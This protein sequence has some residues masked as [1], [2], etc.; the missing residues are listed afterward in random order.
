MINPMIEVAHETILSS[1]EPLHQ[2]ILIHAEALRARRDLEHAATEWDKSGRPGSALRT[3]KLLLRY[4]DAAAPRSTTA[5]AYLTACK[6]RRTGFRVA[7]SALGLLFILT[8]GILFHVNKS[9]YPP[10]LAAKALFVQLGIWPVPKPDMVG[11][12]RRSIRHG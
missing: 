5:D 11:N 2:W 7:F 9:Q 10:S 3:G 4:L 12:P 8:L 6:Q 1:W